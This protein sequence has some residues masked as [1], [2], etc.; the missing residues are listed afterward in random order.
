MHPAPAVTRT[1]APIPRLLF[2]QVQSFPLPHPD[3]FTLYARLAVPGE[4]SFLLESG[5]GPTNIA[6]Y[7]FLGTAPYRVL[8][9][10]QA[11]YT[12]RTPETCVHHQGDPFQALVALVGPPLIPPSPLLPPFLGGAV[13]LLSYDLVRHFESLPVQAADDLALPDLAMLFV[14]LL[15][16]VDHQMDRLHLIFTP[17]PERLL[18]ESH[19][20]LWREGEERIAALAARLFEPSEPARLQLAVP[21]VLHPGQTPTA[22]MDRVRECQAFIAAGDIYQANLSHRFTI[23]WDGARESASAQS[24]YGRLRSV[25]P[26]PFAALLD[27]GD[28]ALVSSSPERLVCVRDGR[29]E[30][31][32]IAGTR[33]RGRTPS[34]NA[35]L[36]ANLL[37]DSKERAEHLMLVD[38]ARNDTGRVCAYGSVKVE[39]FMVVEHYSHVMHLVSNVIGT[40]RDSF[41]WADVIRAVFPG[42][43]ITGVPKIRCMEII[44]Q[45]EPVRRGPYTGSIGYVSWTGE[46]DLNIVIRTLVMAH[47]RGYLQVGAGIVADSDPLRE[48]E[49][50]LHKAQALLTALC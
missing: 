15:A 11:S 2:P 23:E 31:R 40:L 43:T 13:G 47:G 16:A 10:K 50:T 32:P 29:V 6:R 45:L 14:E 9:G 22:Y 1:H 33:P 12:I 3:V 7:S 18:A 36:Q 8:S 5:K 48:Y 4:P 34:E 49:E 41:T 46:M 21:H 35:W 26:A 37:A 20:A 24:L 27:F 42:G 44:E 28:F 30:A 25:N 17:A 19:D 38:L 39:E